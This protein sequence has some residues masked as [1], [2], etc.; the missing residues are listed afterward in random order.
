MPSSDNDEITV[1]PN[2]LCWSQLRLPV[3]T[4]DA[5][6]WSASASTGLV[7]LLDVSGEAAMHWLPVLAA[8]VQ[9][10]MGT[11]RSDGDWLFWQSP[12]EPL[13]ERE[14]WASDWVAQQVQRWPQWDAAAWQQHVQ[15]FGLQA[16]LTKPLW[17]LS[18]GSVRKL[19]LAAALASG[20]P[21]TLIEE[22]IA[23]LDGSALRYLS[24]ALELLG[25]Q[26]AQPPGRAAPARW[27]LVA[28][29]EA[30]PGVTWDEVLELPAPPVA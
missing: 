22:P 23:G 26:L 16:Q 24:H 7:L 21:V 8:Q 19:W 18:T 30:L 10:P 6:G 27:V 12:R 14:Q 15:G 5:P 4:S 1:A 2:T 28:H 25:E 9:T 29:W 3:S 20:A 11:S 13:A 17:H